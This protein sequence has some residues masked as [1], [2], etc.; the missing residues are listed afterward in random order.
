[1]REEEGREGKREIREREKER[2]LFGILGDAPIW[3]QS[4]DKRYRRP[5]KIRLIKCPK[6]ASE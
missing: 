1:M 5:E 4:S 2:D 6:L 3:M